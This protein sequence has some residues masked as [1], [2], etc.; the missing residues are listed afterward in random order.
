M[1]DLNAGSEV[2]PGVQFLT[3]R[4]DKFDKYAQPTLA[5]GG[6]SG[7]GYDAPALQGATNVVLE[8]IDHRETAFSARAFAEMWRFLTGGAAKAEITPESSVR[9]TGLITGYENKVPTNLPVAGIGVSVFEIDPATGARRGAA[10]HQ[11]TTG[12]DGSWGPLAGSPTAAYEFVIQQPGAAVRHIFR[13]PFPRSSSVVS[14]RL[15]EDAATPDQGVVIFT[16]PRGYVATGRDKH[17][18]DGAPVPGVKTGVPTDS[19]FKVPI[20]GPERAVPTSLNGENITARA[21]PGE[22]VYAEFHY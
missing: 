9:L 21:I 8:G 1:Q 10:A 16:R 15:T 5:S 18:L 17:L 11:M 3:I 2:V 6:P 7:I 12:A 14:M 20:T 19:S 13:S 4:S 22:V